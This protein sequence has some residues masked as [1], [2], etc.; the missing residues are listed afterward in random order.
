MKQLWEIICN[1]GREA[2]KKHGDDGLGK[3]S[4]HKCDRMQVWMYAAVAGVGAL[5]QRLA[6]YR[7]I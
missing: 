4:M 1:E 6:A 2:S 7:M 5:K 3:G